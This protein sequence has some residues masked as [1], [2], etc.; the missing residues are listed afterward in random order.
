MDQQR[1][2]LGLLYGILGMVGFSLTL[3]ATRV[4]V[5]YFGTTAV[6]L[7]RGLLAGLLAILLVLIFRLPRPNRAE[8]KELALLAGGAVIGF[9]YLSSWSMDRLPASHGAIVLALLPLVTAGIA[10]WREG[11]HP[12][13]LF[14]LC[15]LAG[16][17]IIMGYA[18][19]Q[20]AGRLQSADLILFAGVVLSA[21]G[22][23]IGGRLTRT[24]GALWVVSWA[25]IV[26]LPLTAIPGVLAIWQQGAD[27]PLTAWIS[28][29][30]LGAGSQLL[31]WILW[32]LGLSLGG[33]AKVS[34]VQLVQ[35]FLTII[36]SALLLHEPITLLTVGAALLVIVTVAGGQKSPVKMAQKPMIM[37]GEDVHQ[38]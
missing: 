13:R 21:Y 19:I 18:L 35:P 3:P 37:G 24:R 9:P 14:W 10:R 23:A 15:S 38:A 5:E 6:G 33:I 30:Y 25:L 2:K 22:Y 11:E 27:A 7:G 28:L 4:S 36:L 8:F 16:S 12:S 1:E 31:A 26:P 20:G 34:Q 17:L 32:C 29:I